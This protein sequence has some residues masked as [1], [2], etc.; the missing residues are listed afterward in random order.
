V[1]QPPF[2]IYQC[3][4][5]ACRFRFP[6]QP[7]ERGGDR[8]PVCRGL[9]QQ[10]Y[11]GESSVKTA[12]S[13]ATTPGVIIEALL[14]NIRSIHNVGSM[15]RTADGAGL[16]HLYLGGITATPA[17][18]RLAKAA[19][20]AHQTVGWSRHHNGVDTAAALQ[21]RGYRLW[22]L[23][24]GAESLFT[25]ELDTNGH[26]ILLIVGNE[27][28]G[29]DPGILERCDRILSLPM[30]GQKGSLN[31]A[32]AFGV[33]AYYLRYIMGKLTIF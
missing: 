4:N 31:A 8:C 5:P 9:V 20:G 30:A 21:Q 18:S 16:R 11:T 14:D 7:G 24:A 25:A 1:T 3:A 33:A 10:V 28:A 22:A 6:A 26:P 2:H 19:L 15:F 17:H 13:P 29:V 12:E 23:E 32:V 27:K